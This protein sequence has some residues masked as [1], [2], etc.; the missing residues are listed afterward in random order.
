MGLGGAA[1]ARAAQQLLKVRVCLRAELQLLL[2]SLK[3]CNWHT[4]SHMSHQG[5][6]SHLLPVSPLAGE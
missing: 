3:N 5:R 2:G 1:A 4:L 6:W